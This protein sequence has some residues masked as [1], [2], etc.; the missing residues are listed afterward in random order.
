MVAQGEAKK[1]WQ[2]T[3][4]TQPYQPLDKDAGIAPTSPRLQTLAK[5]L[6]QKIFRHFGNKYI[7]KELL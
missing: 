1:Q 3:L 5:Q 2:F 7:R 4:I 6:D